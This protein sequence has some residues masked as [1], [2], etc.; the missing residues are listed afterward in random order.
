L[1]A[2]IGREATYVSTDLTPIL[3]LTK[4]I[5]YIQE[6]EIAVL[7]PDRVEIIQAEDGGLV[8]RNPEMAIESIETAQKAGYAHFMLK[9]IHEQPKVVGELVRL[10]ED[11][12]NTLT[13]IDELE[14]ARNLYLVGCSSSYHAALLGSYYLAGVAGK[15][16]IPVMSTQFV[17]QYS[18]A[19]KSGD[20]AVFISQS[21]ETKDTLYA[22]EVAREHGVRTLGLVNR[23]GSTLTRVT[24]RYLPI[25]CGYENSIPATKT[26]LNQ[27]VAMLYLALQ[28]GDLPTTGLSSLP[29]L[30]SQTLE[31]IDKPI[32]Q[33]ATQLSEW[34][35]MYC[36]GLGSTYPIALEGALKIKEITYAHCEGMLST[37]FKYGPLSAV[38]EDYPIIF[39]AGPADTK[40][41]VNSLN[42]VACRGGCPL[43]IGEENQALRENSCEMI[44]LP[45]AG[46]LLNPL[47]SVMPLQLLAY[48]M[49]IARSL[50]PD[51]PRNLSKT[52]PFN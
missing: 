50:D 36:L 4:D 6:D 29:G 26:F 44:S 49:A 32:Q 5:L 42:E 37:E 21:G 43:V 52:I 11:S 41:F 23:I 16:S 40:S 48:H 2:G 27:S 17:A 7:Y 3:P 28:L 45:Q 39:V 10:L 13:F 19:L 24:E 47:I 30:L 20:V 22:E 33:L 18:P 46:P 12:P 38:Y 25:A 35:E 34:P 1:V 9:E 51:F 15:S 8:N 14:N 31:S